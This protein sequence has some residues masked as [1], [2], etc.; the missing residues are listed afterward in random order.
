MGFGLGLGLGWVRVRDGVRVYREAEVAERGVALEDVDLARVRRLRV[1]QRE[2]AQVH[3]ASAAPHV[4][5]G[6][7]ARGHDERVVAAEGH[8]AEHG[9]LLAN[10]LELAQQRRAPL[11][12]RRRRV[13]AARERRPLCAAR[14]A[15]EVP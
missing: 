7:G 3:A 6:D 5:G 11:L 12:A 10:L 4:H 1:R 13:R 8:R 15:V 2:R 14:R 9:R